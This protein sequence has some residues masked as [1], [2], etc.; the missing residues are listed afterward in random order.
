M[1]A[2]L[3]ASEYEKQNEQH[4]TDWWGIIPPWWHRA[5]ASHG[6]C[7][8]LSKICCKQPLRLSKRALSTETLHA[9]VHFKSIHTASEK[10]LRIKRDPKYM[11]YILPV[12]FQI[13]Q[14][15]GELLFLRINGVWLRI[16]VPFFMQ[17]LSAQCAFSECLERLARRCVSHALPN[18]QSQLTPVRHTWWEEGRNIK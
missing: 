7:R 2:H 15:F 18:S 9:L 3:V 17:M 10:F 11:I 5:Q 8:L 13:Q 1:F 14:H 12:Y 4:R 6:S 16:T